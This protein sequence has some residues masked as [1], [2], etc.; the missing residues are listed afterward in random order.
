MRTVYVFFCCAAVLGT[1]CA[2]PGHDR[3]FTDAWA[4]DCE[5][6]AREAQLDTEGEIVLTGKDG[7]GPR[8]ALAMDED[9]KPELR[10]GRSD[11][12]K[13]DLR[14]SGSDPEIKVGYQW[15]WK[16]RTSE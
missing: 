3:V 14:L 13:T 4:Y 12:W 9:G 5:R 2:S 11:R 7:E 16:H 15:R 10:V 8:T 6:R 1:G